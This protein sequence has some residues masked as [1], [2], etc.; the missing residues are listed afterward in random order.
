M[1]TDSFFSTPKIRQRLEIYQRSSSSSVS[2]AAPNKYRRIA[3]LPNADDE[4]YEFL[5]TKYHEPYFK[6]RIITEFY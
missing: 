1:I 2:M 6:I 5:L 4:L 3:S